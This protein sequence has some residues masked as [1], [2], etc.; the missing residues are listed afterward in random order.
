MLVDAEFLNCF[1]TGIDQPQSML[2]P[3][4][5]LKLGKT[6]VVRAWCSIGDKRAVEVHL[7]VDQ[8]VVRFRRYL[9][10]VRTHNL[11]DEVIV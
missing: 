6:S 4:R 11:F 5:K 2:L 1:G 8:V 7:P 3:G 9:F 10:E